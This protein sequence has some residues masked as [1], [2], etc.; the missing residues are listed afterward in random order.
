MNRVVYKH[1]QII[2]VHTKGGKAPMNKL[3][4]QMKGRGFSI[5]EVVLVL[6]IAGLIF[7]AVFIAL[8]AL[9]ANQRDSDRKRDVST[10]VTGINDY[11]SGNKQK[12]PTTQ[13]LTGNSEGDPLNDD[14]WVSSMSSN[15]TAVKVNTTA[16]PGQLNEAALT[17]GV[18]IITQRTTCGEVTKSAVTLTT[19]TSQQFTVVT[20]LEAGGG[21]FYCQDA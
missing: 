16:G 2:K 12:F 17:D 20:R 1:K 18:I 5:I 11:K 4:Q 15:T 21:S 10:V 13:T 6:A 8:P 7:L 14:S 9:Q 3:Y 19:G